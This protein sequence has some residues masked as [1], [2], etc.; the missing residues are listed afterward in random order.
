MK[1]RLFKR[2]TSVSDKKV[3]ILKNLTLKILFFLFLFHELSVDILEKKS[4][5]IR[6]IIFQESQIYPPLPTNFEDNSM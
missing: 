1:I 3:D 4:G 5:V 2:K 6:L